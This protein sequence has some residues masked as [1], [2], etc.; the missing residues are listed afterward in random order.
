MPWQGR[1]YRTSNEELR[2]LFW[3]AVL[4]LVTKIEIIAQKIEVLLQLASA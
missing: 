2:I 4:M 1:E 3:L